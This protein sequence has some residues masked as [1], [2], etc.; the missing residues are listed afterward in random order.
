LQSFGILNL[1]QEA[2]LLHLFQSLDLQN[3]VKFGHHEG[4]QF[5]YKNVGV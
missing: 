1:I 5:K 2:K 3:L 4:H